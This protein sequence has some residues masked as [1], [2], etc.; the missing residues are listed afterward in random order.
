MHTPCQD[1]F[2]VPWCHDSYSAWKQQSGLGAGPQPA[3]PFHRAWP[4]AL[5]GSTCTACL[6]LSAQTGNACLLPTGMG[7]RHPAGRAHAACFSSKVLWVQLS[8]WNPL[9]E[10]G[11]GKR[12]Q[13]SDAAPSRAVC[14]KLS[15]ACDDTSCEYG[16]GDGDGHVKMEM[17]THMDAAL[18]TMTRRTKHQAA[19]K[20]EFHWS[21][22][23]Q[24]KEQTKAPLIQSQNTDVQQSVKCHPL[25]LL[26]LVAS[27]FPTILPDS[28]ARAQYA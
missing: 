16:H 4:H 7:A 5:P 17:R 11:S 18:G 3:P 26:M 1:V 21:A 23:R 22:M 14:Q 25:L 28:S 15:R 12:G 6:P 19:F 24:D 13:L 9:N 20:L 8:V 10:I 2:F 27:K